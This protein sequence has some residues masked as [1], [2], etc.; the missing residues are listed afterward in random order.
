MTTA[1]STAVVNNN[2]QRQPGFDSVPDLI[3]YYVGGAD[4]NAVLL[5]GGGNVGALSG[6]MTCS[7]IAQ[8]EVRLW[9]PCNRRR[10]LIT[11]YSLVEAAFPNILPSTVENTRLMRQR[12]RTL[13]TAFVCTD[14]LRV[15][16]T[17][18]S[19]DIE[20]SSS[21]HN[22]NYRHHSP[23]PPPQTSKWIRMQSSS[24]SSIRRIPSATV[25]SGMLTSAT[26]LKPSSPGG[27]ANQT[28]T[29]PLAKSPCP[30][31]ID[32]QS[33]ITEFTPVSP[34]SSVKTLP[35]QPKS[36][37]PV[38]LIS[39]S[40]S[41]LLSER[42]S[43]SGSKSM[44]IQS[45]LSLRPYTDVSKS[46]P[47]TISDLLSSP[48][49]SMDTQ[50]LSRSISRS[51]SL[52]REFDNSFGFYK[53]SFEGARPSP[54]KSPSL[55]KNMSNEYEDDTYFSPFDTA[56]LSSFVQQRP[57][58]NVY[59][60]KPD[61]EC[62]FG[63]SSKLY[64]EDCELPAMFVDRSSSLQIQPEEPQIPNNSQNTSS[65]I[66]NKNDD[67]DKKKEQRSSSF[68]SSFISTSTLKD[69]EI[70]HN[71]GGKLTDHQKVERAV[72]QS[73]KNEH[74]F[75]DQLDVSNSQRETQDEEIQEAE[76]PMKNVEVS[77]KSV[78]E[79]H[80]ID[81]TNV[82][83]KESDKQKSSDLDS[84]VEK[85][86]NASEN[87]NFQNCRT[88][89]SNTM[90][91]GLVDMLKQPHLDQQDRQLTRITRI[92]DCDPRQRR[93]RQMHQTLIENQEVNHTTDSMKTESGKIIPD[94]EIRKLAR[95]TN[96][97][98]RA[99]TVAPV[100]IRATRNSIRSSNNDLTE[101][102]IRQWTGL[103]KI[104]NL[105]RNSKVTEVYHR[106]QI[107]LIELLP[108]IRRK[109]QQN[110]RPVT[111]SGNHHLPTFNDIPSVGKPFRGHVTP[112]GE[113]QQRMQMNMNCPQVSLKITGNNINH[114]DD[115]TPVT[116][117]SQS[118]TTETFSD[119]YSPL[120]RIIPSTTVESSTSTSDKKIGSVGV[121]GIGCKLA[122][123]YVNINSQID[124]HQ[125]SFNESGTR[126]INTKNLDRIH[127][128]NYQYH[129]YKH[130]IC[131][132]KN[133]NNYNNFVDNNEPI[134]DYENMLTR[135][136]D[137]TNDFNYEN[138]NQN[139][140][141]KRQQLIID[142]NRSNTAVAAA[143]RAVHL[144]IIGDPDDSGGATVGTGKLAAAMCRADGRTTVLPYRRN[145]T[146]S[147]QVG[148]LL[149]TCPLQ[150]LG[151]PG[152]AGRRARLDVIERYNTFKS[153]CFV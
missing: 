24:R 93:L 102:M 14:R 95:K 6:S 123:D 106:S 41:S 107:A 99:A 90:R 131:K 114:E 150:L 96:R 50:R 13:P 120:T 94:I 1:I 52:N 146:K 78:E 112:P 116:N 70:E 79:E 17:S 81:D 45:S 65:S 121:G 85:S 38:P 56:V 32:P 137:D 46:T 130:Q 80:T 108:H 12:C 21:F 109:W 26:S 101:N 153:L 74:K 98:D 129:K 35:C 144:A 30:P 97:T 139:N 83:R 19:R 75:T 57:A 9:Y 23:S 104:S 133:D 143:L 86:L 62:C 110:N 49:S 122:C 126:N 60:F 124:N 87:Q 77:Q 141:E 47:L 43:T 76:N 115:E 103:Q 152:P 11:D 48:S 128:K 69:E 147:K 31:K 71:I 140:D 72:E 2:D 66:G 42:P 84:N 40:L 51:N 125:N 67:V 22:T 119:I 105:G 8:T 44:P 145:V 20:A 100:Q 89:W 25:T 33:S 61:P 68:D 91:Q 58:P 3:R 149:S 37:Y 132:S 53:K 118:N 64:L 29:Q 34:N 136:I 73:Q 135:N 16:S 5:Y 92:R 148:P 36:S 7:R 15:S 111:A 117:N 55:V 113:I 63:K 54:H 127:H 134:A 27:L 88:R 142:C 10:P 151:Q 18:P 28:Q 39:E 59:R 138:I 4:D 82:D